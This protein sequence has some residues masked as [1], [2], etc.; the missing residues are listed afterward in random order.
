M[1]RYWRM[2][3][4]PSAQSLPLIL[5]RPLDSALKTRDDF[6]G[7]KSTDRAPREEILHR[8][9]SIWEDEG[10]PE[11]RKLANWLQAETEVMSQP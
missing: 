6:P 5:D 2:K 7:M 4:Y 1:P 10:H 11:N 9:Y 8:A 3:N